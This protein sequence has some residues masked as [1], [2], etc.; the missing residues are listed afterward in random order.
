MAFFFVLLSKNINMPCQHSKYV[1]FSSGIVPL[2]CCHR[3]KIKICP[4]SNLTHNY[5]L[6]SD[7]MPLRHGGLN[8]YVT[9]YMTV[10]A[11]KRKPACKRDSL[12]ISSFCSNHGNKCPRPGT[13]P[14]ELMCVAEA[15]MPRLILRLLQHF[16]ENR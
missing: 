12:F 15:M 10:V 11:Q 14:A 4:S 8:I 9:N 13:A 2:R 16:R 3:E 6:Q 7:A 1:G 5:L